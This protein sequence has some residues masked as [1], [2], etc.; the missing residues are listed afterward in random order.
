MKQFMLILK[1]KRIT[2][3]TILFAINLLFVY[4]YSERQITFPEILTTLMAAYYAFIWIFRRRIKLTQLKFNVLFLSLIVVFIGFAFLIFYKIPLSSLNVD[5]W[6]VITSFWDSFNNSEWVYSAKSYAGNPPGPMPFY[7]ILSLPFLLIGELGVITIVGALLFAVFI[8]GINSSLNSKLWSIVFLLSSFFFLWEVVT[9]SS[10]FFNSTLILGIS[11]WF[12]NLK[13]KNSI[14]FFIHAF[15]AGLLLSTRSIFA[16]PYIILFLY[17]LRVKEVSFTRLFVYGLIAVLSFSSSFFP[18]V[19]NHIHDFTEI[20]PFIIQSTF[21]VPFYYTIGF[22]TLAFGSSFLCRTKNDVYFFSGLIL[23]ISIL[24]YFLYHV[25][26]SGFKVAYFESIVDISYFIFCT[27][28]LIYYLVITDNGSK[29][30]K[31]LS[32]NA[33]CLEE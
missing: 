17:A 32:S 20:N 25:I 12:F 24:V 13:K 21:L 5:R 26:N 30:G 2:A 19:I 15:I 29:T 33:I 10:I 6:S 9:R 11:I 28:F 8:S 3:L 23:F 4:K 22:L 7:F 27:P 1:G 31:E 16:I 18:F 14:L